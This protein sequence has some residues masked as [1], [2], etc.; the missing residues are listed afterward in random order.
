MKI[1]EQELDINYLMKM[2]VIIEH[3]PLHDKFNKEIEAS[4]REN[5]VNLFFGFITGNYF[6]HM[7]PLHY[8]ANYYGEKMGFYFAWL[9]FYTSWLLLPAIPGLALFIY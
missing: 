5:R 2:G 1:F 7:Q 8:I 9:I 6:N 3:F 4:W